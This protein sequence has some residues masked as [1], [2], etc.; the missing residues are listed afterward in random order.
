MAKSVLAPSREKHF[1][2][3]KKSIK[4]FLFF[5]FQIDCFIS[6]DQSR[7][8]R[9]YVESFLEPTT[10]KRHLVGNVFKWR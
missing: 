2:R 10:D 6:V 5:S 4:S 3:H 7:R 1:Q 8:R 9:R